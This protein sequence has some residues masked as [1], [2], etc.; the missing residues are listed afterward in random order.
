M[1]VDHVCISVGYLVRD[2]HCVKVI[3]P[4]ISP[5][6]SVIDSPEQ[7]CGSMAIPCRSVISCVELIEANLTDEET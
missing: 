4:H 5:E 3:V 6:D 7:G 2:G 1:D